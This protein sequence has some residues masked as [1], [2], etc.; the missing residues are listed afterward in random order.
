M[1]QTA[2]AVRG[3]YTTLNISRESHLYTQSFIHHRHKER[4]NLMHAQTHTQVSAFGKNCEK[5]VK[6]VIQVVKTLPQNQTNIIMPKATL[7]AALPQELMV[8][9]FFFFCVQNFLFPLLKRSIFKLCL[10]LDELRPQ[11]TNCFT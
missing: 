9:W 1:D 5:V 7:Y 2:G 10:L 4:E 8:F 6:V 11:I 3:S